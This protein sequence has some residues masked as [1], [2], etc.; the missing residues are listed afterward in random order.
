MAPAKGA[1]GSAAQHAGSAA[2]ASISEPL[3]RS[4]RIAS[5]LMTMSSAGL[6][7]LGAASNST[8]L[9]RQA[10]HRLQSPRAPVDARAGAEGAMAT[11]TT[12]TAPQGRESAT[13]REFF[14]T[15][16]GGQAKCRGQATPSGTRRQ[17]RVG[18]SDRAPPPPLSPI[19][20]VPLR[21]RR[22]LL[23]WF[24]HCLAGNCDFKRQGDLIASTSDGDAC[25]RSRLRRRA[26]SCRCSSGVL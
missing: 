5:S 3:R 9:P 14:R 25:A 15:S 6:I 23:L 26:T 12:A 20:F 24:G 10:T 7:S 4:R 13:W 2:T 8:T 19:T 18:G 16:A 21:P 1:I 17:R 11:A 22:L